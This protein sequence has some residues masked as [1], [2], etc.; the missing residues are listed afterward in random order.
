[1]KPVSTIAIV[2]NCQKK[3]VLRGASSVLSFLKS[4]KKNILMDPAAATALGLPRLAASPEDLVRRSGLALVLGGDGTFLRAAALF[5]DSGTPLFGI[6]FGS[7]GFLNEAVVAD[8]RTALDE[9]LSGRSRISSRMMLQ[10]G[11]EGLERRLFGL[12][13]IALVR[14]APLRTIS[15]SCFVNDRRIGTFKADGIIAATP[16]GSTAYNLSAQG[17]VMEPEMQGIIINPVCPHTLAVRPLIVP[18]EAKIRIE[19]SAR[20]TEVFLAADGQDRVVLPPGSVVTVRKASKPLR[21]VTTREYDWF[22]HLGRKLDWI[23]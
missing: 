4:R 18:G 12:N 14:G 16:T 6:N 9:V 10:G 7:I 21:I 2:V 19:W 3:T 13:E 15:L 23:R 8:F 22:G 5:R 17:P 1:M 11:V 20:D